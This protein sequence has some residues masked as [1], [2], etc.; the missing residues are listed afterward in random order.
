MVL[1][2]LQM[3]IKRLGLA[4]FISAFIACIYLLMTRPGDSGSQYH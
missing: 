2:D 4:I 1:I 3:K